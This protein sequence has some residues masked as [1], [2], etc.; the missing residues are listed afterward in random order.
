MGD[1]NMKKI[2]YEDYEE[3][4]AKYKEEYQ[5]DW[6]VDMENTG[7]LKVELKI[8]SSALCEIIPE[9]GVSLSTCQGIFFQDQ[10]A[11][12]LPDG[13]YVYIDTNLDEVIKSVAEEYSLFFARDDAEMTEDELLSK[14]DGGYCF[15][16]NADP[17]SSLDYPDIDDE[18]RDLV[19]NEGFTELDKNSEDFL[20][21]AMRMEYVKAEDKGHG[22]WKI[23]DGDLPNKIFEVGEYHIAL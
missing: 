13:E 3:N 7:D 8:D 2:A 17:A 20:L 12:W 21:Y 19:E 18:I 4:F 15:I 1:R 23:I 14:M 16:S 11:A 22:L 6:F 9:V 10:V 5:L